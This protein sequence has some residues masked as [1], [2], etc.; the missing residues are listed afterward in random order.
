MG[1][2]RPRCPYCIIII[3]ALGFFVSSYNN[4]SNAQ[5]SNTSNMPVDWRW[6]DP[7]DLDGRLKDEEWLPSN[8][9]S[10]DG[11]DNV[12]FI[13]DYHIDLKSRGRLVPPGEALGW[14][15]DI[16]TFDPP[17]DYTVIDEAFDAFPS[18]FN[19]HDLGVQWHPDGQGNAD[20]YFALDLPGSSNLNISANVINPYNGKYAIAFDADA[21]E[22][23]EFFDSTIIIHPQF[24]DKSATEF[25][26][27]YFWLGPTGKVIKIVESQNNNRTITDGL[28]I[29]IELTSLDGTD[30]P[31]Q[32]V[33]SARIPGS[34]EH[35]QYTTDGDDIDLSSLMD[36][37]GIPSNPAASV[38]DIEIRLSDIAQILSQ[39]KI[40][41]NNV[42]ATSNDNP[43]SINDCSRVYVEISSGLVTDF[44]Q[45]ES[46]GHLLK[47]P[48]LPFDVD[49]EKTV[50]CG[51]CGYAPG[52]SGTQGYTIPDA[53]IRFDMEF[54]VPVTPTT[55]ITNPPPTNGSGYIVGKDLLT[56]NYNAVESYLLCEDAITV[57]GVPDLVSI[58]DFNVIDQEWVVMNKDGTSEYIFNPGDVLFVPF[59]VKI[60]AGYG[61]HDI[62]NEIT[63]RIEVWGENEDYDD[64]PDDPYESDVSEAFVEILVP[65]LHCEKAVEVVDDNAKSWSSFDINATPP[66]FLASLL[67]DAELEDIDFPITVTWYLCVSNAT[68]HEWDPNAIDGETDL[69]LNTLE[70]PVLSS[71]G[72]PGISLPVKIPKGFHGCIEFSRNYNKWED[73]Y[74]DAG[75]DYGI[76][77]HFEAKATVVDSDPGAGIDK[78]CV[79]KEYP[80]VEA[81]SYE[82]EC[83]SEVELT[84]LP[85]HAH[86]AIVKEV[87]CDENGPWYESVDALP[88]S[89]GSQTEIWFRITVW[90]ESTWI[91][92]DHAY[93]TDILTG[94][95]T[96]VTPPPDG[97]IGPIPPGDG[98]PGGP[99]TK[100]YKFYGTVNEITTSGIEKDIVNTVVVEA[101]GPDPG[102]EPD[103]HPDSSDMDEVWVNVRIPGL[104]IEKSIYAQDSGSWNTGTHVTDVHLPAGVVWPVL[105][106]Y[107]VRA[108]IPTSIPAIDALDVTEA[109]LF[110]ELLEKI[111]TLI[112]GAPTY[113]PKKPPIE[114]SVDYSVGWKDILVECKFHIADLDEFKHI[115]LHD[116]NPPTELIIENKSEAFF[117]GFRVPAGQPSNDLCGNWEGMVDDW[118][119]IYAP[120]DNIKVP[121]LS[122]YGI[123]IMSLIMGGLILLRMRR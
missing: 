83:E 42:D 61:T 78:I 97:D 108:G 121:A 79:M 51:D 118:A 26:I 101:D 55:S 8:D 119:R 71:L 112:A 16:D 89:A 25:Y 62:A 15:R 10:V 123:I 44:S 46:F 14:M 31:A 53:K 23:A 116:M 115:A 60:K 66:E 56:D 90:N 28:P 9:P 20:F 4:V 48:L 41:W 111:G 19:L 99:D 84:I 69:W 40:E 105:V 13:Y 102:D 73:W 63:N 85:P 1:A 18:G 33:H 93:I 45:E 52:T 22:D 5:T 91:P 104:K 29:L 68:S 107:K 117:D 43:L 98:M 37:G 2:V 114:F 82:Q 74:A 21:N 75:A 86:V 27:L 100:V 96:L 65:E 76:L 67:I 11:F 110:D 34:F 77:N 94:P 109:E 88:S 12:Q 6:S 38:F 70:D 103:N 81:D 57:N 17:L 36:Y 95:I 24:S 49:V 58:P 35:V 113:D 47:F 72:W 30:N 54:T 59:E 39:P 32:I 50:G 106:K 64:G 120:D 92:I 87:S 3:I 122:T 7:P 80:D